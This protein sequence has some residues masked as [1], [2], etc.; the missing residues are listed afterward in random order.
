M[1]TTATISRWGNSLA[2][3]IPGGILER[4]RVREGD[5]LEFDVSEEG[6][7]L[8]RVPYAVH[9]PLKSW[10]QELPRRTC[11]QKRNGVRQG[12]RKHGSRHSLSPIIILYH[13]LA[14]KRGIRAG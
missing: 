2:V 5:G 14:P 6:G 8:S 4:S 13:P 1:N 7:G 11:R 10:R 9:I 3:R 12:E